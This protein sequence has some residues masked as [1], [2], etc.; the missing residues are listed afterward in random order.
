MSGEGEIIGDASI[1]ANPRAVEFG[2]APLLIRST[3]TPGKI[4]VHARVLFEGEHAATPAEIE[5]ESVAPSVN[6]VFSEKPQINQNQAVFGGYQRQMT[7]EEKKNIL[8]QVE[9]QQTEFGEVKE[10][11]K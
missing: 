1:G 6:M 10:G 7:E 5:F 4:K 3:L 9:L 11:T 2:S 8:N